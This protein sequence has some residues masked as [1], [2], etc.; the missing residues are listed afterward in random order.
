MAGT[1]PF[2]VS[3]VCGSTA[4]NVFKVH[5]TRPLSAIPQIRAYDCNAVFPNTDN[6]TT[7]AFDIFIGS[8]GNGNKSML[9]F[10]DTTRGGP[11]TLGWRTNSISGAGVA[12]CLMKGD[13]S[14][15]QFRYSTASVAV[16][17]AS[18]KW[19][20]LVYVPSDVVPNMTKLHNVSIRFQF[21]STTPTVSFY[22]NSI[23]DNG[24]EL[25]P[26]WA[27]IVT[28]TSGIKFTSASGTYTSLLAN[29]PLSGEEATEKAWATT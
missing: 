22:G 27:T 2:Q 4:S 26:A 6:T 25:A 5:F 10:L 28:D 21:T 13:S 11:P 17:G 3:G 20:A 9:H 7:A 16:A 19:N 29:I 12:T 8:A 15:L 23:R 24:T 1:K 18:L 14:Y